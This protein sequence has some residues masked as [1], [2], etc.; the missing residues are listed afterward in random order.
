MHG[1]N[2]MSDRHYIAINKQFLDVANFNRSI[3]GIEKRKPKPQDAEE[4]KLS[5]HQLK[6]EIE[7]IE[8]SFLDGDFIGILDGLI[9]LE[10]FLLGISYKSGINEATHSELFDAVHQANLLKTAGVKAGREGYDAADAVK[11]DSWTNPEVLFARI[12]DKVD[13]HGS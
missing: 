11:P 7:E 10:Y 8:T 6:E 1:D 4:F 2:K 13:K 9:D 12:L 3:L 5:M